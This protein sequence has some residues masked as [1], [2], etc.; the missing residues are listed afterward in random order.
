MCVFSIRIRLSCYWK[1]NMKKHLFIKYFL[2][3]IKSSFQ[4]YFQTQYTSCF[5]YFF[6]IYKFNHFYK[7]IIFCEEF[8]EMR[9][10]LSNLYYAMFEVNDLPDLDFK[11]FYIY[12]HIYV[13][14]YTFLGLITK[15]R[16]CILITRQVSK[17]KCPDFI[18]P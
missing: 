10:N 3:K 11:F 12:I 14:T 5:F 16:T 4:F 1:T 6:I 13:Y 8:L 2:K 18:S 9:N 15:D 7:S 17:H